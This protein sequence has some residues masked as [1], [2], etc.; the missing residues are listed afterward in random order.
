M[1]QIRRQSWPVKRPDSPPTATLVPLDQHRARRL[2]ALANDVRARLH[3]LE[4]SRVQTDLHSGSLWRELSLLQRQLRGCRERLARC[5]SD[6]N[7]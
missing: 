5:F 1:P 4:R 2:E 7:Q 6:L 3:A